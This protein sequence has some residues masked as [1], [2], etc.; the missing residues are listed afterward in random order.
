MPSCTRFNNYSPL[1]CT[2]LKIQEETILFLL[3]TAFEMNRGTNRLDSGLWQRAVI[4]L[5]EMWCSA[6]RTNFASASASVPLSNGR[7]V[8]AM[9]HLYDSR[10]KE[11]A[12]MVARFVVSNGVALHFSSDVNSH[13]FYVGFSNSL[14]MNGVTHRWTWFVP[15]HTHHS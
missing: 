15:F 6:G 12:G 13:K 2:V 3:S 1:C 14:T 9:R 7:S 5:S 4:E 8:Q 11:D 10:E